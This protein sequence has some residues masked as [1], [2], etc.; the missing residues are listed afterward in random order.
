MR[1]YEAKPEEA[2]GIAKFMKSFEDE[3][4][5]VKVDSDYAGAKYEFMIRNGNAHMFVL[6]EDNKMV[7]GLGCVVGPDLHTPRIIA[8]ETYWYVHPDYRGIGKKLLDYFEQ[9]AKDAGYDATA[10]IC[11]SDSMSDSLEHLYLHREYTLIEK[12]FIKEVKR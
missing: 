1:I 5:Y 4:V 6:E 11:L 3:T 12:H 10:M 2:R 8:V 7:G 9:W